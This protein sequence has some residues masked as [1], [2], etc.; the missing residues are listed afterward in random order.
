MKRQATLTSFLLLGSEPVVT[1]T[2]RPAIVDYFRW[3]ITIDS[4]IEYKYKYAAYKYCSKLNLLPMTWRNRTSSLIVVGAAFR[5]FRS[6]RKS[7]SC[8]SRIV[9]EAPS[10]ALLF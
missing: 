9:V 3:A 1:P 7:S 2:P 8:S 6:A 10:Q 4:K 5:H